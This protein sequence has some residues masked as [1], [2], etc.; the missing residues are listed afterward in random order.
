MHR[1]ILATLA[2]AAAGAAMAQS[3]PSTGVTAV[4]TYES[5]GL[6]WSTSN[7]P[8]GCS[9][10]YR[11]TGTSAWSTG[12]PLWF[13][14][15]TSE[16]RGSIVGL[17]P[18]TQY[19]AQLGVVGAGFTR[20]VLFTTWTNHT[21]VAKTVQVP[22]GGGTYNVAEG[23][24]PSGYVVY[25]GAGATR[26]AQNGARFNVT[27]NASYVVVRNLVLRGA[28]QDA[29]RI[30]ANVHDVIIE[31]NDISGWGR[32]RDGTWG[33]DMDS[34]VRAVC[35]NQE[36]TRVTV[37][38][39]RMHDPRYSANSWTDG[40]PAGPQGITFSYCG[41]N[42]VL[43]WNE[44]F[45]TGGNRFNDGMGG[46]D[47]FSD[48]GFPNADSDIYGNLITHTWDDAIEA[49]GGNRNVRI[50]G[51]YMD[52][53]AT[54]VATT[55]TAVGPVYVF[56]NVFNRNQF[57]E[58]RA[59][60]ADD[61]QPFFKSGSSGDF[62]NGR[63]YLL[64]NTMLQATAPGSS[65]GLGGGAGVGGTGDSQPVRN[66]VSMNNIYHLWKPNSAVYQVGGDN[67]FQ[68]DMFNGSMGTAVVSGINATPQYAAGNGW[69]SESGGAYALA[70]GTP[71]YDAGVRIPNFN[72]GFVGNAPDV[73][74]AEA[75][76]GAMKFGRAA[77]TGTSGGTA[78]ISPP[79][80][81]P[82]PPPST[83]TTPPPPG[84]TGSAAP[85]LGLD[86]S[87]YTINA[88]Q[89]VTL[90]VR[91]SGNAGT[92]TGSV[93]FRSDGA[94]IGGCGA[95]GLAN[96][97]AT[98]TTSAIGGGAHAITGV[99]SGSSAYSAGQAGPITLTVIGGATTA[100][101]LPTKFG[102]DSSS[103]SSGSGQAVTF[104]A[105]IP[106]DGGTVS[107]TSDNA[108]IAGCG[109]VGVSKGYASC[110]TGALASGAHAIRA[111]YSG[112]GSYG[113]GVAGP[114]T[115]TVSGTATVPASLNV[116]GLWWGS[117]S[118]S[119]WGVNLAQQG[120]IVFATWFTYDANGKGQWLVMS[121]GNRTSPN[122]FSGTLYRTTGPSFAS[123]S[124]DSKSV[125][126]SAVGSGTF[127]FSDSNNGVFTA[128]VNGVTVTKAITRQVY[129]TVPTCTAGG[130]AGAAPNYQDLWWRSG[131]TE[132]GWGMNIAHQ[133][134]TLFV[135]WFT[136]DADG[137]QLWL[138]ASNVAKVGPGTYSGTLYRTTGPA[139]NTPQW[140]PAA[141]GATPVGSVTLA[142]GD[143]SN[144]TF[145]YTVNGVSQSKP[146]SRQVFSSPATVCR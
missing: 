109:A 128:T 48:T 134:D 101:S 146:I 139:F 112:S 35:S 118:E 126:S 133:R 69:Q 50:W 138:V 61:R 135:T 14:P 107:F 111:T 106:G 130:P 9:V 67:T 52:R 142:F 97:T 10:Q 105:S 13:D 68:S 15:R 1:T 4:T 71:G 132:S 45:S 30:A 102:I 125:K 89:A 124:F 41:G 53:T 136:Y 70:A 58:N 64:H 38:R 77:S 66:T 120:D 73:G 54:G 3:L 5:A 55:L 23:G 113:A 72:D 56:R 90:G 116:Q 62:S 19:E 42:H 123:A 129:D 28:Q 96:G 12:M 83:P 104:T 79:P 74:A 80:S 63:R 88:G 51:N 25:D 85:S 103:Y 122:S 93:D 33:A 27:I 99:Y 117:A 60:D 115:Q 26:D 91:V 84:G 16:C 87:A 7:A 44:I 49:E 39:N 29:I 78:T 24:S 140:S 81:T 20:G 98:C 110:T 59:P 6:Y 75:G 114:I 137:S 143:A 144:G 34:A 86:A 127:T 121:N 11:K 100:V 21:P 57:F 36:M 95:V 37:Q 46:E 18:G 2:L 32:T 76:A 92:A 108:P 119:G 47:N 141:V 40:H 43:R 94:S 145:T 8:G 65:Y 31:D 22:G 17:T 82:T 131:G